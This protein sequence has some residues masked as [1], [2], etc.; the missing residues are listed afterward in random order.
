MQLKNRQRGRGKGHGRLEIREYHVLL[1]DNL[2]TQFTEWKCLKTLGQ[3][4]VI[5]WINW[6]KSLSNTATISTQQN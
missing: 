3:Q 2:V 6:G 5:G 1:T 4:S